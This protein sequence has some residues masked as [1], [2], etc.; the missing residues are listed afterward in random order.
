MI[1][2]A[3][4]IITYLFGGGIFTF[5]NIRDAAEEIIKDKDRAKQVI[6]ITKQADKE[7]KSFAENLDK[8]SKQLAQLNKNYNLTREELDSFSIQAKQN[9]MAFLEKFI[10][11]RFQLKN[12]VTAEEW[13]AMHIK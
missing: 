5:E 8:L 1:V 9:R 6:S 7:V 10:E 12:L 4:A 3:I 11:L 2:G 13:Q